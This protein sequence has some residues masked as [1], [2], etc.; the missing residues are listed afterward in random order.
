V[1]VETAIS[2]FLASKD[3]PDGVNDEIPSSYY[4]HR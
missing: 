1:A 4:Y 2:G 3:F